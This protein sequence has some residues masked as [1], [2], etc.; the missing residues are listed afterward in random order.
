MKWKN[1]NRMSWEVAA[2][3]RKILFWNGDFH[4]SSLVLYYFCFR[5]C[6]V[7]VFVSAGKPG[8]DRNQS[9]VFLHC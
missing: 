1:Q 4:I 3:S 6:E 9:S 5:F 7:C 2:K 8:E